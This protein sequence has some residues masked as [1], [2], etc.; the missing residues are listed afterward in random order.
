M[1]PYP[2][3]VAAFK[4]FTYMRTQWRVGMGGPIGLDYSVMQRKLD[5]MRLTP[6]AYDQL[7]DDIREMEAVALACIY[8][9]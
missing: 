6:E 7:E 2:D 8:E 3:N 5:R 9:K 4:L 1:L